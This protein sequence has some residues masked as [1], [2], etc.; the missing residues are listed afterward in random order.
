MTSA[1]LYETEIPNLP[2]YRGKVR[3]VYDLGKELLIVATDRVSAFDVVF[4]DPIPLKG[5]VL[6]QI[7]LWWFAETGGIVKNH[8]ITADIDKYPENL[9]PYRDQLNGRSMI[10]RKTTPLKGEF[11]VRGYLDGSG[12]KTYQAS[13]AI[14]GVKLMNGLQQRSRLGVPIFTPTTKADE[15]HDLPV[16]I[17]ELGKIVGEEQAARGRDIATEL[18]LFA[19]NRLFNHGLILSD[20]KFEFGID[21]NE[22]LILI[23]EILTPD[24]SRFWLKETYTPDSERPVSLDKQ[25]IRDHV[26]STGWKKEPPAPKLPA[27]VIKNTTERYLKAYEMITGAKLPVG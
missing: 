14:C 26:D 5:F 13:K 16:T 10:V 27:E 12:W 19:H 15:G 6:T 8:L 18:Y 23:D 22:E 20:T 3:D 9:K 24:S 4:P 21:E 11:V 17:D 2:L 1:P 7:S 25:Y